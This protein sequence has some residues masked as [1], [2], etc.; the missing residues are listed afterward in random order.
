MTDYIL[1]GKICIFDH[2]HNRVWK[3][4]ATSCMRVPNFSGCNTLRAG[5]GNLQSPRQCNG[6]VSKKRTSPIQ[7]KLLFSLARRSEKKTRN[8]DLCLL[9]NASLGTRVWRT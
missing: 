8:A 4:L 7:A 2:V 3:R 1:E 6:T 5:H 9:V